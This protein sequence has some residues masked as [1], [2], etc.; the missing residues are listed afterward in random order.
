[1]YIRPHVCGH[2]WNCAVMQPPD[3]SPAAHTSCRSSARPS[4]HCGSSASRRMF[5]QMTKVALSGCS[6]A[7]CAGCAAGT[8][9]PSAPGL[10]EPRRRLPAAQ[11]RIPLPWQLWHASGAARRLGRHAVYGDPDLS[12]SSAALRHAGAFPEHPARRQ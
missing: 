11:E 4:T 7:A 10:H 8:P 9:P 5:R 3:L 6:S 1:M 2:I 12:L